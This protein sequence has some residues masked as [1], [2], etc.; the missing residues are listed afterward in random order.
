MSF[1][2]PLISVIIPIF[3]VEKYLDKCLESV[4]RQTYKDLEIIL[5]DDGSTDNSGKM[6]DSYKR[7]YPLITV[8]HKE[9]GGLSDAR[10]NGIKV[11]KGDYFAFLDSDDFLSPYFFEIIANVICDTQVDLVALKHSYDFWDEDEETVELIN[12]STEYKMEIISNIEALEKMF[13][14]EIEIGAPLKI[15]KA[16]IFKELSFPKGLLY[17][18]VATTYKEFIN[19][20]KVAIVDSRIYAY[21]KRMDSIIRQKF[22]NKK[23]GIIEVSQ[24]VVHTIGNLFPVLLPAAKYRVFSPLFSVFLQIPIEEKEYRKQVW[25][26]ILK[27]R[28]NVIFEKKRIRKK[29]RIAALLTYFGKDITYYIGKKFGQKGT[30]HQ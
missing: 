23:M 18:D 29:D 17:E 21:R 15:C 10:N 25:A 30:F 14:L 5:V 3:N 22:S 26:E 7:K 11:A 12:N 28:K 4:F 13:Y 9:N 2:M 8:I 20:D 19:V 16:E 1:S 27:Y 24:D 6:C